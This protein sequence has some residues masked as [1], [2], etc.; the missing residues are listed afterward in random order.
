[1]S[2]GDWRPI[3]TAPKDGTSIMVHT[4]ERCVHCKSA[5][6]WVRW[7]GYWRLGTTKDGVPL[8]FA[9][10]PSSWMPGLT[11]PTTGSGNG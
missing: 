1:M 6:A 8:A 7:D 3:E 4:T 11:P 2:K 9:H 5:M 10:E